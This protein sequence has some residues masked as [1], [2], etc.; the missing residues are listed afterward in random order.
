MFFVLLF[1]SLGVYAQNATIRIM[2]YNLLNY[3]DADNPVAYKDSRLKKIV[4][5]VQ[6]D[7]LGANEIA[8]SPSHSQNILNKVLGSSWEKGAFVNSGNEIQ[9][10]MLFWRADKF[11][12]QKQTTISR[13]LRDIIA[14]RLYYKD[15]EL[16]RTRDTVFIT[17]IVAHL[18][19][20]YNTSDETARDRETYSVATYLNNQ[21]AGNYIFMG[22][23]NL[24]S[25]SEKA[26]TNIIDN[27][28]VGKLY[29]PIGRRGEWSANVDYADIHTQST[30][31]G[32][33]SDGGAGGGLDD[34]FDHLL[35]SNSIMQ[36]LVHVQY[37]PGTYKAVG[38]DGKHYNRSIVSSPGNT[39]APSDVIQAL[40]EMSDHLPVIADFTV[41]PSVS[42]AM[43]ANAPSSFN[44][45]ISVAT[46][47]SDKIAI[48]FDELLIGKPLQVD[49]FGIDG[50]RLKAQDIIVNAQ[51]M[52][53]ELNE[54]YASSIFLLRIT[55][56]NG[57]AI[58]KKLVK[59]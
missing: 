7:I 53:F 56:K 39:S 11:A 48:H 6:P 24:Y 50:R 41:T 5:Y 47:V 43:V 14:F 17:V 8:N 15:A 4:D 37:V 32:S 9:T 58:I 51:N 28:G 45:M 3:G 38:N 2:Q 34:R 46:L 59:Y 35:V 1:C 20:G 25:A 29:D 26:Y 27:P 42:P 30:R 16:H 52:T 44:N 33:L 36:N 19:A 23:F 54:S 57:N 22:D 18:K 12:L 10:N 13:N 31:S 40:Y 21:G 55:D 49:L